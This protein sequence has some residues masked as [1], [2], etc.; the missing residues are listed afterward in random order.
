MT[1]VQVRT[2]NGLV[3]L[4]GDVGSD[5]ERVAAA[6]DAAGIG[7]VEALVNSLRV[8]TNP[9]SPTGALQKPSAVALAPIARTAESSPAELVTR[10]AAPWL[11]PTCIRWT[12]RSLA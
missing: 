5:A 8:I 9:Q 7:G 11:H 3:T 10:P 1:H 12:Q 6:Q 4:S 2:R